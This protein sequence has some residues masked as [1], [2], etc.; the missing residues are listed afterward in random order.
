MHADTLAHSLTWQHDKSIG[1][2]TNSRSL[3][4]D[5][6]NTGLEPRRRGGEEL[7]RRS[8]HK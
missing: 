5:N 1:G 7:L 4:A 3:L 2:L 6:N 8:E